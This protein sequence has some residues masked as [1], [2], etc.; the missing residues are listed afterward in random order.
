VPKVASSAPIVIGTAR[1]LRGGA[2]G[3]VV[4][5]MPPR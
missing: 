2:Y 4:V 3:C 1:L 5:V